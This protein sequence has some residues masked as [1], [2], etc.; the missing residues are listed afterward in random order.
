MRKLIHKKI[1]SR[2]GETMAEVLVALLIIA[3]SSMLLVSMISTAASIDARTRERDKTF[4]EDLS[5][6]ETRT[7]AGGA[8]GTGEVIITGG[9]A[10]QT[11]HVTIYGGNGLT[12]YERTP[13]GGGGGT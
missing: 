3:L 9:S 2:S 6:A 4:Y 10:S 5:R 11:I 1:R 12:S 13:S 7:A 8:A